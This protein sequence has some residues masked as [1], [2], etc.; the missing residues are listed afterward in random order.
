MEIILCC[1]L[2]CILCNLKC[3]VI[4][5]HFSSL[6]TYNALKMAFESL[7]FF[8]TLYILHP[9]F[10]YVITFFCSW[11]K[12]DS[13]QSSEFKFCLNGQCVRKMTDFSTNQFV[14]ILLQTDRTVYVTQSIRLWGKQCRKTIL[15]GDQACIQS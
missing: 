11:N 9:S 1:T 5:T 10:A 6:N 8:L 13:Y 2:F 7:C 12:P 3:Q 4:H 14:I 15:T